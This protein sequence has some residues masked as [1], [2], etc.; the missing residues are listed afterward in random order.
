MRMLLSCDW[1]ETVPLDEQGHGL[2]ILNTPCRQSKSGFGKSNSALGW[3]RSCLLG[4]AEEPDDVVGDL[5]EGRATEVPGLIKVIEA[6]EA[7]ALMADG[8]FGDVLGDAELGHQR[9]A[10]PAQVVGR[11]VDARGAPYGVKPQGPAGDD[12]AG[13][14]P[15]EDERV[16][17]RRLRGDDGAHEPGERH[18]VFLTGLR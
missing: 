11:E 17:G 1:R 2:A 5:G 9:A 14:L 4:A 13:F 10:G 8:E 16:H 15:G 12:T 3:R 18:L 7:G 6:G